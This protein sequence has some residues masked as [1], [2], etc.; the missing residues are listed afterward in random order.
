MYNA[1]R[2]IH[3]FESNYYKNPAEIMTLS[4][5]KIHLTIIMNPLKQK[6]TNPDGSVD[7]ILLRSS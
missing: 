6:M 5:I 2:I 4:A 1:I 3:D 7:P